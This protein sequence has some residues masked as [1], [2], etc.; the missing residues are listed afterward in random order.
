MARASIA[1]LWMMRE[2]PLPA[3]VCQTHIAH[4]S[5]YRFAFKAGA[6]MAT[7][8]A[9]GYS[10]YTV[11]LWWTDLNSVEIGFFKHSRHR[12]KSRQFSKDSDV[13]GAVDVNGERKGILTYRRGLWEESEGIQ[14]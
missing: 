2:L 10:K 14:K 6:Q 4:H 9:L 8:A 1:F 7:S 12:A 5:P 3:L 13:I 11:D